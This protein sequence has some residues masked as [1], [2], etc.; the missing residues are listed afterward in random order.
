ML[1]IWLCAHAA[2]AACLAQCMGRNAPSIQPLPA[3]KPSKRS[4]V[5]IVMIGN[6]GFH[7]QPFPDGIR[8][9]DWSLRPEM[10]MVF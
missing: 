5:S 7:Q 10:P 8:K 6:S 2:C 3:N 4:N 1:S 9:Y